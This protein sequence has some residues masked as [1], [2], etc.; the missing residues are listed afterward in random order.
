MRI[1]AAAILTVAAIAT[2][3]ARGDERDNCLG[4]DETAASII[5]CERLLEQWPND[6]ALLHRLAWLHLARNEEGPAEQAYRRL[7]ELEPDNPQAHFEYAAALAT[8]WNYRMAEPAIREAI[9]LRPEHLQSYILAAV[10]Y[11]GL[12]DPIQAFSMHLQLAHRGSRIGMFDAAQDFDFGRGTP[13]DPKRAKR[14]YLAAAEAGHILA[15]TKLAEGLEL[16][17]FDEDPDSVAAETWRTRAILE[18][19]PM[20]GD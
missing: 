14:W 7:I 10:I 9:A 12:G 20:P 18:R 8:M 1:L 5:A 4:G 3:S 16:G 19:G 17:L 6:L 11:E 13:P 2:S 15:M